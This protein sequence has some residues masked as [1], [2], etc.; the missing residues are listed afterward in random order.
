MRPKGKYLIFINAKTS[1]KVATRPPFENFYSLTRGVVFIEH[2]KKST[3]VVWVILRKSKISLLKNQ[4]LALDNRVILKSP[5]CCAHP[6]DFSSGF[7]DDTKIRTV[8]PIM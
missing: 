5:E 4:F 3:V 7:F 2:F 8:I 6:G 1:Q